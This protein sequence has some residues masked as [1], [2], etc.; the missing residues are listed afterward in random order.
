MGIMLLKNEKLLALRTYSR[1]PSWNHSDI[2]LIKICKIFS[3][4]LKV[5][6]IV[7]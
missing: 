3:H 1:S 6:K 5:F 4:V 7:Y 2:I